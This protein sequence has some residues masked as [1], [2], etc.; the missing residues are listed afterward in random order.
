MRRERTVLYL[1]AG[2]FLLT[3]IEVR[4]LHREVLREHW[5]A[6][7]P[8]AYGALGTAVAIVAAVPS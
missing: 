5:Q 4:Y 3:A 8:V 2:G 1:L 7:V 6:W